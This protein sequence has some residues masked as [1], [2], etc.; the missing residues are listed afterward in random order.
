LPEESTA[1][2]LP[3]SVPLPPYHFDQDPPP[4][5]ALVVAAEVFE[6]AESPPVLFARTRN[7]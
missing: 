5:A 7:E 1:T 6:Y 3:L 2:D 4:L